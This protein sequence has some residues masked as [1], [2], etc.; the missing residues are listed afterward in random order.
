M[1]TSLYINDIL[2]DGSPNINLTFS[3]LYSE[4]TNPT[5]LKNSFSKTLN[6]EG[7]ANNDKA[8][9][10]YFDW[11]HRVNNVSAARRIP[12]RIFIDNDLFTE[13]YCKLEKIERKGDWHQY[14][15]TLYG[16]LG[17]F[18]YSIS[19]KKLSDLEWIEWNGL[20]HNID[21]D[22]I[23]ENWD[24]EY[25]PKH[26]RPD[27][28]TSIHDIIGY[29][30]AYNG[31]YDD[32][33][34]SHAQVDGYGIKGTDKDGNDY[35][36]TLDLGEDLDE[37]NVKSFRSYKQ[38]PSVRVADVIRQIVKESGYS[39]NIDNALE[40]SYETESFFNNDNPYWSRLFCT[41][42]LLDA[43]GRNKDAS[44]DASG[45]LGSSVAGYTLYTY[46]HG[47][48][49]SSGNAAF[50][51]LRDYETPIKYFNLTYDDSELTEEFVNGDNTFNMARVNSQMSFTVRPSNGQFDLTINGK[52]VSSI[53]DNKIVTRYKVMM[54]DMNS[55]NLYDLHCAYWVANNVGDIPRDALGDNDGYATCTNWS[56]VESNHFKSTFTV[57][58][59]FVAQWDNLLKDNDGASMRLV[60]V[61]DNSSDHF[62]SNGGGWIATWYVS[63][64]TY[65]Y[66]NVG[67]FLE[68]CPTNKPDK[69]GSDITINLIMTLN[70][71]TTTADK[72]TNIRSG[73][74]VN[75]KDICKDDITQ[76]EFFLS[77][78]KLFG[79]FLIKDKYEKK[80]TIMTRNQYFQNYKIEDWTDKLDT[81]ENAEITPISFDK[82]YQIFGYQDNE[83]DYS[84]NYKSKFGW[85][86]GDKTIDTNYGFNV[87]SNELLDNAIFV[88]PVTSTE[89][90]IETYNY[91]QHFDTSTYVKTY[92]CEKR[93][94]YEEN[95]TRRP[96]MFNLDGNTRKPVD[97]DLQLYFRLENQPISYDVYITDDTPAM[98]EEQNYMHL[99]PYAYKDRVKD[100]Y[101][102]T[103]TMP[104]YVEIM[105]RS[106]LGSDETQIESSV[107]FAKPSTSF[108][109]FNNNE[110]DTKIFLYNQFWKKYIE[111]L[112]DDDT[113]IVKMKFNL[114]PRDL[115]MFQFYNLVMVNNVLYVVNKIDSF[116]LTKTNTTT[117]ELIRVND[118]ENYVKGQDNLW[119][120]FMKWQN[121]ES[122]YVRVIPVGSYSTVVVLDTNKNIDL[123][124]DYPDWVTAVTWGR[125]SN[126]KVY[127]YITVL[128]NDTGVSRQDTISFQT[129]NT[130]RVHAEL[131]VYQ[132]S[133]PPR[134]VTQS[135]E[136]PAE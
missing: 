25:D 40:L 116:N 122:T 101:L 27:R 92:S 32:F 103:N 46:K 38:R 47:T 61:T 71:G 114:S 42:P 43:K 121:G 95:P 37:W 83:N 124:G 77:W 112:Y 132:P 54:K 30:P 66:F 88:T 7:T 2:I 8:F 63:W 70:G 80:I 78:L 87:D 45:V 13:G 84:K 16:G 126:N 59:P 15:V 93:Y 74:T 115:M 39:S 86:Y 51:S 31:T 17:E 123:A 1:T 67:A 28:T 69:K 60:L 85:D 134:P 110:V 108:G 49:A 118:H 125:M 68:L 33:D 29:V 9:E 64:S 58:K 133:R 10:Q 72:G 89:A 3:L 57:Q 128:P 129:Y 50:H 20:Q 97:G 117:V 135:E 104:R 113:E 4:L 96:A 22:F 41:M 111:D 56:W 12:F 14:S 19:E 65:R 52:S 53:R 21:K 102:T 106:D 81:S 23:K 36:M 131:V 62:Y 24:Y 120:P 5:T 18:L 26:N 35:D 91:R 6:I 100:Y 119:V 44:S 11:R 76:G 127:I 75:W 130:P 55:G 99:I 34:N 109:G 73:M 98:I 79:L 94:A 136:E 48:Y 82:R 107:L 105:L 90:G